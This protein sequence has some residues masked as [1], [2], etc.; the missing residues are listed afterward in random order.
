LGQE[1]GGCTVAKLPAELPLDV[2][3]ELI[4]RARFLDAYYAPAR[5]PDAFSEPC[6]PLRTLAT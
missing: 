5:Y 1:A 3:Q 6:R 4:E 2:P